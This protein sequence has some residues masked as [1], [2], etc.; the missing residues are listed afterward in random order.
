MTVAEDAVVLLQQV[1]VLVRDQ[2]FGRVEELCS[3]A[4]VMDPGNADALNLLGQALFERGDVATALACLKRAAKI[5]GSGRMWSNL[6]VVLQASRDYV[7]G[8]TA[9]RQALRIDPLNITTWTN[10]LFAMD[11]HPEASPQLR[12]ADR[13]AFNAMHCASLTAAA[14]PHDNDRDPDRM[15]RIGYVSADFKNHSAS[16][17][18]GPVIFGADRER[19]HLTLYDNNAERA[20]QETTRFHD[21]ADAVLGV[22]E[23]SDVELA[24]RIRADRIDILVD[25]TGYSSGGRL[26]VFARRPAPIQ[27]TGWG[28]AT[29][30]GLDCM[31]YLFS[32]AVT[33]PPEHEANYRERIIRLPCVV[34]FDVRPPYPEVSGPP[35]ERNGYVTFGY[36]GRAYKLNERCLSVWAELLRRMP[37]ARLI[38]KAKEY[39]NP[40]LREWVLSVFAALGVTSDRLSLRGSTA[41]ELHLATY[42][43]V[44]VHLD[45]FPHGGGVTTLEAC[46]MGVPT[47]TL[48]GDY[49]SGRISAS[50]LSVLGGP[51]GVPTTVD[52]YAEKAI[53]MASLPWNLGDRQSLRHAILSSILCDNRGYAAS[54]EEAYRMAWKRWVSGDAR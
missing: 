34:G 19:F 33:I 53:H 17:A 38:L 14:E 29:G 31:D 7:T 15:L 40:V 32:D 20:D 4:L 41:R 10:L 42:N 28:H 27:M 30:T 21:A 18:F 51:G 12:M 6:G 35:A 46:L 8:I 36:L 9:Y 3:E 26:P 39:A 1:K 37:T 44:D 23:M 48:L 49:V 43:E 50:V 11:H 5:E 25:L 2:Q 22:S 54:V 52:G 24:R 13:R 45:P 16:V 47:V